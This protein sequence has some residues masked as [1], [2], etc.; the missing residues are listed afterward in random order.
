MKQYTQNIQR[1][2]IEDV[3]AEEQ[4]LENEYLLGNYVDDKFEDLETKT[5]HKE[6]EAT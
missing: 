1:T 5:F 2:E 3:P 6:F 4:L